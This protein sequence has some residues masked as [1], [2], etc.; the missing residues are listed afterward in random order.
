MHRTHKTIIYI[1]L[2]ILTIISI[3]VLCRSFHR[4]TLLGIDYSGIL[5]GILAALCTV[6]I[7]W[8]I[9]S[10]IDFSKREDKNRKLI[11]SLTSILRAIKENGNRGDYLLNDNLSDIYKN[12]LTEDRL[13]CEYE[14]IHFKIAA[15]H[16]AAIIG[17]YDVCENGISEIKEAIAKHSPTI[18]EER[19]ERLV[20]NACSI[21][22]QNSIKNFADLV[23]TITGIKR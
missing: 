4:D 9:Y 17:E 7:G 2:I 3:I 15:I 21:P 11:D 12:I 23:N 13:R 5:V 20:R 22:N 14:M 1:W 6:L 10:L 19:K 18:S 16:H 8:Q